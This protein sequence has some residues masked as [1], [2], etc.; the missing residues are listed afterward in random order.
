MATQDRAALRPHPLRFAL[1]GD[2]A[3]LAA[4]GDELLRRGHEVVLVCADASAAPVRE[5]AAQ[6]G[7][8]LFGHEHPPEELATC[9]WLL[10]IVNLRMLSSAWLGAPARGAIN[11]HD[12]PLPRYA[13]LNTTT[14]A[15]LAGEREHGVTWHHMAAGADRG[16]VLV[17]RS[18][19][20]AERDTAFALNA[21]CFD[22]GIESFRELAERLEQDAAPAGTPQDASAR[23]YFGRYKRPAGL[24]LLD[25][26]APARDVAR[27][28]SALDFGTWENPMGWPK[29][30]GPSDDASAEPGQLAVRV[31]GAV[32]ATEHAVA[33]VAAGTIVERSGERLVVA[34]AQGA[35]EFGDWKTPEG[36]RGALPAA[37]SPGT[38]LPSGAALAGLSD[39]DA[40]AQAARAE[41][42]WIA[43]LRAPLPPTVSG[44]GR[45]TSGIRRTHP[46]SVSVASFVAFLARTSRED[47]FDVALRREA[48]SPLYEAESRA[49]LAVDRAAS[50]SSAREAICEALSGAVSGAVIDARGRRAAGAEALPVEVVVGDARPEGALALHVSA[51][52]D[53]R[54]TG[55]GSISVDVSCMDEH[56]FA[57]WCERLGEFARRFERACREG[58]GALAGV[59]VLLD[60]EADQLAA[61]TENA[62]PI[63]RARTMV[64]G[65]DAQAAATPSA[66]A[67]EDAV[68]S[69][70][71]AQLQ[72]RADA[73]ASRLRE[74]GVARGD[75]VGIS[76]GRDAGLVIAAW[77]TWIAGAAYVPLDPSYPAA[78]LEL[79]VRD[80]DL[81]CVIVD[82]RA[83]GV[84][85][86]EV[87]RVDLRS[88][89]S[90]DGGAD[91]A[92]ARG[93]GPSPDDLAYLI[94]TSGSTG[95]PKGVAVEHHCVVH[96]CDAM[97][98]VVCPPTR[99][100][101]RTWLALTS[102]NFD[103]SV[104]ELFYP[105]LRGDR[106]RIPGEEAPSPMAMGLFY[107]SSDA[108]EDRSYRLLLEGARF[109]DANGFS[110]VWTPERHFHAFGGIYPNPAVTG[111]A[112]AAVTERVRVMAG[113]CVLPLHHPAR[114]A[115]DWAVVDNL[116][117]GRAGVAFAAGWQPNDFVLRPENHA[118]RKAVM[119]RDI[120]T[121]RGLWRGETR[122]FEGPDGAPVEVRTLPRPTQAELPVWL[123][124][125][126]NPESFRDAGRIGANVLTHLLGQSFDEVAEKI[127]AYRDAWAEAGHAGR[128]S[129]SLM[130]HTF[131]GDSDDEVREIVRAPMKRYLSS[132]MSLV[133]AAAWS[134]PTFKKTTTMEDGSFSVQHLGNDELDALLDHAFE[135]YHDTGGLFGSEETALQTI[136]RVRAIDVD[137]IVCLIDFGVPD[138]QVLDMLPRL[139]SIR[140]RAN[141][142]ASVRVS[143]EEILEACTH[144]QCVP[145]RA[146]MLL[147]TEAGRRALATLDQVLVGGEA[148]PPDVAEALLA[149]PAESGARPTI[150]N[151]YGPTET[152]V[153]SSS[154]TLEH[155]DGAIPIGRPLANTTLRV[156]DPSG[157]LVPPGDVGELWIGG[158]GVVRGYHRRDALTAERFVE[159]DGERFY[160]TGDA[161]RWRADGVLTYHGRLD[162]QVKVRGYRIELG[163]IECALG[164]LPTVRAAAC[165]KREDS[166]GDQRLVAYLVC[167]GPMP[168]ADDLRRAL[169]MTLPDYM[170][171]SAFVSLPALPTTPNGKVD[172]RALPAPNKGVASLRTAYVAPTS[173]LESRIAALW[174]DALELERVGVDDNFFDLGGHS[175]LTVQIH[176]QLAPEVDGPLSL[177]DLFRFPTVRALARHLSGAD[178]GP[179]AASKGSSRAAKRKA[180]RRRR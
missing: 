68:G 61:F 15:L 46:I 147:A 11:F 170:V 168:P 167:D 31:P 44:L 171:P 115:E 41:D 85:L 150:V 78:R 86:G 179:S 103:I 70:T 5:W 104:L 28:V 6:R 95:T 133:K 12:G 51:G 18:V 121:V 107:F 60:G 42:A 157:A 20:I 127:R 1:I 37:W 17:Q 117:Q 47:A 156:V 173:A 21:R 25:L 175:L 110:S 155:A 111:A 145:S 19:P 105:L 67:I 8:A 52:V 124:I 34:C 40:N 87:E 48:R 137:E 122:A 130:L 50:C 100:E 144:V 13:G 83:E 138:E 74:R 63:E 94:Y 9:D 14:W 160:R 26:S 177:V 154:H 58:Q 118:E 146:R 128:G 153:W 152:T 71:Y 139:A 88:A 119:L 96:F 22:A 114:V 161:V 27:A 134:F 73:L 174:S 45:A 39:A 140:V 69:W 89:P 129:V 97:D 90:A 132:A 54:E 7:I 108:G 30:V 77:A 3:L 76:T 66:I 126:G 79:M 135:R 35:L 109:A 120:E 180:A 56:A 55:S 112:V 4:C 43:R 59:S 164:A 125:A 176:A 36:Q 64:D 24:G 32:R 81:R 84:A 10:S 136:D 142:H 91:A 49:R 149:L 178:A 65:L 123:T 75:R 166:P 131:V 106:I 148:F 72:S 29:I 101:R 38:T 116:S 113:S 82:G 62:Q 159:R 53:L 162:D 99:G 102:L 16:N 93:V 33:D 23:T 57:R 141:E 2:G 151:V 98:A 163:E 143:V 169:A 92:R 165:A 172:R 158:R 80:A